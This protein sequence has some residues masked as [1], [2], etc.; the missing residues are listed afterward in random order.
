M[1]EESVRKPGKVERNEGDADAALASAA[2]V[3]HGRVLRAA[4]RAR[5]HGAAGRHRAHDRRQVGGVGAGA[6]PRRRARRHRQGARHQARGDG[7]A[8]HA[9][10]R[11]LRPQVEVRLRHRGGAAVQGDGRRAGQGGVDARGR[12]PARLLSHRDGRALRGGPRRQ[13]QGGG[14]AASQRGAEHP[15]HLRARSEASVRHRARHGMGRH[16]VRRAQHPHG[17]RRG[18]EPRAHRLV[19]LG[20][21]RGARLVDPVLRRRDRRTSSARTRRT[22]CSS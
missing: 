12:H 13:Q 16:A 11:R 7:A 5:D 15:V 21:Q 20:Q 4:P 1:L 18:A 22:S 2:K 10:R 19:P 8:H 14:L 3:D 6:E 17:E 9:A